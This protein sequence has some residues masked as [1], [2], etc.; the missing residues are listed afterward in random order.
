MISKE[1]R[2]IILALQGE[3]AEQ[4]TEE[5]EPA[6]NADVWIVTL[7]NP[8]KGKSNNESKLEIIYLSGEKAALNLWKVT[9]RTQ[10]GGFATGYTPC[11]AHREVVENTRRHLKAARNR[12]WTKDEKRISQGKLTWENLAAIE[13]IEFAPQVAATLLIKSLHKDG[14]DAVDQILF[15]EAEVSDFF[16]PQSNQAAQ[17]KFRLIMNKQ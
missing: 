10:E 5:L 17:E 3:V 15:E 6:E 13:G 16:P 12:E 7:Y 4:L 9:I 1:I 2:I 11:W 14:I 8:D